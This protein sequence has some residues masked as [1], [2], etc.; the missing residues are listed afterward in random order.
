[1]ASVETQLRAA[2]QAHRDAWQR[3]CSAGAAAEVLEARLHAIIDATM[4]DSV[5]QWLDALDAAAGQLDQGER[6]ELQAAAAEQILALAR[7]DVADADLVRH[8]GQVF[9][10]A[11]QR[12]TT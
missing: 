4:P 5:R 10:Q 8:A 11:R 3:W 9:D 1:M 12:I 7:S 2:H 6:A